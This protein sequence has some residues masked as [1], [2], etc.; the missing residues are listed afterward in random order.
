M[1]RAGTGRSSNPV[2]SNIGMIHKVHN[3][4]NTSQAKMQSKKLPQYDDIDIPD[5]I[6]NISDP[7]L[8]DDYIESTNN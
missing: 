7:D 4:Y 6:E 8:D 1:N 5:G 2:D 3:V